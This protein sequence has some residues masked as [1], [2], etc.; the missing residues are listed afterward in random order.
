MNRRS[1]LDLSITGHLGLIMIPKIL[2]AGL[3]NSEQPND[4]KRYFLTIT[5]RDEIELSEGK[6]FPF[7]WHAT[8]IK[9]ENTLVFKLKE[10][11]PGIPMAFR[12]SV[13]QGARVEFLLHARSAGTKTYLG[14]FDIRYSS[15]LSIYEL[16]IDKKHINEIN[17]LGIEVKLQGP[18]SLWIFDEN[19]ATQQNALL[20]PHFLPAIRKG[21]INDFL[22]CFLSVNS[23][24][25]FGWR[26]GCVLDG[27]W[28]IHERKGDKKALNTIKEHLSLFIDENQNLVYETLKGGTMLNELDG[29]EST[30]PF[31]IL[32]KLDAKHQVL[33][34][35]TESW[36]KFTK[37]RRGSYG[38]CHNSGR[39]LYSCLANG[40]YRQG[41]AR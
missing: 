32:A 14:A 41:K 15:A 10:K 13:A 26:E 9:P 39:L 35:V 29:I 36:K 19:I 28:Q 22:D 3:V 17:E 38:E 5:K 8:S 24:Q 2:N 25:P 30:L 21:R 23:V 18:T 34:I 1:F 20:A 37:K 11:L 27:L 12:V 33:P 7:G 6:R 31:A 16:T 40:C 4:V